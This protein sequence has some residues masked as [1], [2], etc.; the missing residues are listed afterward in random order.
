MGKM[1]KCIKIL[2]GVL[3]LG[4]M[5][6]CYRQPLVEIHNVGD[7]LD[8]SRYV[9]SNSKHYYYYTEGVVYA[10]DG[11][12]ICN[13]ENGDLS[14]IAADDFYFYYYNMENE[15]LVRVDLETG[16]KLVLERG[17]PVRKL[18]GFKEGVFVSDIKGDS[19]LKYYSRDKEFSIYDM[20][21]NDAEA[22]KQV[23]IMINDGCPVYVYEFEQY[24]ITVEM[25]NGNLNML[26]ICDD[27]GTRYSNIIVCS[28]FV[29]HNGIYE[30]LDCSGYN[31]NGRK[32]NYDSVTPLAENEKEIEPNTVSVVND[33]I[34]ALYVSTRRQGSNL[35]A[36]EVLTKFNMETK[37]TET[38]YR[39]ENAEDIA[40]QGENGE[41]LVNY[42][43]EDNRIYIMKNGKLY[44]K[45]FDHPKDEGTELCDIPKE[46][47]E[48]GFEYARGKLFIYDDCKMKLI[49]IYE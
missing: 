44:R 9:C 33:N 23:D 8:V 46:Y 6:G 34:Y 19:Y 25:Q 45:S 18:Y 5:T 17:I 27:S 10:D 31:Y 7:S 16:E 1:K 43:V 39:I 11:R 42:S 35:I 20:I 32:Y 14:Q 26:N 41:Y 30:L 48:L 21:K 12:K 49:G 28:T 4:L 29:I 2:L 47:S 36:Q 22:L 38:I 37:E 40:Y 15:M 13:I 3:A 24:K